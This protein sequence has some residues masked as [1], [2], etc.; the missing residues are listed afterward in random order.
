MELDRNFKE[1]LE[2][3]NKNEVEYLLVGG[4]AIGIYVEPRFTGDID[5]WVKNTLENGKKIVKTIDE[6]GLSS[7]GVKAED[8]LNPDCILQIGYRPI[9]IDL[10]THIEGVDFDSSWK[11]KTKYQTE[12][13]DLWVIS[14]KDLMINKAAVAREQDLKDLKELK[15]PK[16]K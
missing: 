13:I 8:F 7:L 12:G 11:E 5:F 6:F 4:Y 3:L 2:L 15:N 9:R 10:L 1:F 16:K 14:K